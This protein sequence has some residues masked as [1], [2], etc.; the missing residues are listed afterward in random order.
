[1][2]RGGEAA[3]TAS[4]AM[5]VGEPDGKTNQLRASGAA[6]GQLDAVDRGESAT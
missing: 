2:P 3:A 5:P 1:M 4:R 6:V